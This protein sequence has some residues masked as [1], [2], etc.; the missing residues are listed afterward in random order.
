MTPLIF[1]LLN[2]TKTR[3][4]DCLRSKDWSK[5]TSLTSVDEKSEELTKQINSALD[6]CAPYKQFKVRQNFRPGIT[7]EAKRLMLERDQTRK[8]I[9]SHY[10]SNDLLKGK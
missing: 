6:E 3:W 9:F 4:I 7:E 8:M 5:V 2:F 1:G 10:N